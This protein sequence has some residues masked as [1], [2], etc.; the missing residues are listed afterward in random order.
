M[1]KDERNIFSLYIKLQ[2][3][4]SH[5]WS[6]S[7]VVDWFPSFLRGVKTLFQIKMI[8]RDF[9]S[10]SRSVACQI[11]KSLFVSLKENLPEKQFLKTL[12]ELQCLHDK[13][14]SVSKERIC[15]DLTRL[16]DDIKLFYKTNPK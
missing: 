14:D 11:D 3:F 8:L 1:S 4:E 7:R 9:F 12:E 15:L 13:I 5:A 10:S 16:R 2:K 6:S